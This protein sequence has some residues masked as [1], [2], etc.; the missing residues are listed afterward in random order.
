MT[1]RIGINGFGRIGR[2]SLKAIL[3]RYPH[4]LSGGQRQR[5]GIARALALSPNLI[6]A[7]EPVSALDLSVQAQILN[8]LARL[9]GE[10][11]LAYLF[12]AHDKLIDPM[13]DIA[14]ACALFLL[15]AGRKKFGALLG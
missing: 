8:L 6:V 3:E 4:E 13:T 5:I 15:W 12:I 14:L 9:R 2:Q 10:L 1:T 11:G 7:D